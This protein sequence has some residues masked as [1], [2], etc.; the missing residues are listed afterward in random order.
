MKKVLIV[1]ESWV[2]NITHI[3]G[4]DTFVTTHYEEAV[5]WLKE[6]I[7]SGGYETV[8]MPAHVAADS[9]PYKLE[10][11]NEYDCIILSDIGSNTFL[12]SNSTFIDCNSNPDRLELIKEYVNNGGAL[13]MV[14]GYMSFTGI[15]AKA[16]F[17]E[18]AIKDVLPITMIDKDDRV[19]K[20]A[21]IIPEVID[22]EHPVLKGIPTE[23]PKFLG[24]N[25]TVARD[26][27][28]V[29]ATIGGNPFVAVGE[30][31]K[32]K[33]AIFSSDCAPHWGPKEFTDWKYY[34][35]L[36]VNM[37]DWLTC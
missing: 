5:K 30:F 27:C 26:N 12:L 25:K 33:S 15:D 22:S 28:P 34:N 19:E 11:L 29:L 2:K 35:K 20:P 21:G 7:E 17:G 31:G 13:I 10:E 16:R 23:W 37:L 36:W 14:G 9:F 24:Y 3:K 8:H 18:T 32:G 4:F 1:G 6:A